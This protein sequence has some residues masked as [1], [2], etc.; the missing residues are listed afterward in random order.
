MRRVRWLVMPVALAALAAGCSSDEPRPRTEQRQSASPPP[1]SPSITKESTREEPTSK[2]SSP[3]ESILRAERAKLAA[4]LGNAKP[5]EGGSVGAA[6]SLED[7]QYTSPTDAVAKFGNC[8]ESD[9][10]VCTT[11][12]ATTHDN[13]AHAAGVYIPDTL[14]D[15]VTYMPLGR[16]AVAI[17]AEEQLVHSKSYPPFV[18]YS[19]GTWKPLRIAKPRVPDADSD[20]V[21]IY[22]NGDFS[23]EVGLEGGTWAASVDAGEIFALPGSP[24]GMLWEHVPGRGDAVVSVDHRNVGAGV[25]RFAESTDHGRTWRQTGVRLPLGGKPLRRYSN[26]GDYRDAVGPGH[27]QAIAM[28]D[29]PPDLPLYLRQLWR[30]DDEEEFRNVP[31]PKNR[32][33]LAG[34]AFA[35]D[36]SLLLAKMTSPATFCQ[37]LTCNLAGRIW[38]LPPGETEMQPLPQAPRLFGRFSGDTLEPSGGGT[39]VA[40]TGRRTIALS[41]DGYTWTKVTPGR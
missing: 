38:R 7:V 25:W 34:I 36:G 18:L 33:A 1:A 3:E 10:R 11:V 2:E 24:G 39:I 35:A 8:G 12:I 27:L 37:S 28:A 21:D 23:D 31:L 29:A 14:A 5:I 20:L 16:G 4:F 22:Y 41:Q 19:N 32:M 15:L 17:K 30:T 26:A 13:W 6:F 40:R 9:R